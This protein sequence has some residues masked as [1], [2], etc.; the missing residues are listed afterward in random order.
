MVVELVGEMGEGVGEGEGE[1]EGEG[2]G[3]GL[4]VVS[5]ERTPQEVENLLYVYYN[6]TPLPITG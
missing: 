5:A 2:E 3:E 6:Y 1:R 4:G